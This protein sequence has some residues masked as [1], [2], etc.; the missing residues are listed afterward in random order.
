MPPEGEILHAF[1]D[2][3]SDVYPEPLREPSRRPRRARKPRPRPPIA[4]ICRTS[5]AVIVTHRRG[6]RNED[7]LD[8]GRHGLVHSGHLH[9][10]VEIGAVAQAADQ[11]GRPGLA[12]GVD[13]QAV[14]RD[15]LD[16]CSLVSSTLAESVDQAGAFLGG[17]QRRF[18]GMDADG[19]DQPVDYRQAP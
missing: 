12:S 16:Q 2:R 5:V 15:D 1:I 17:K 3:I 13:G 19:D 7:G 8:V 18:A 14:E 10:I 9:L 6:S 4:A 11:E